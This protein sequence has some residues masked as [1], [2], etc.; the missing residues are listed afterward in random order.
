MKESRS[1]ESES[2]S[3]KKRNLLMRLSASSFW[4]LFNFIPQPFVT[5]LLR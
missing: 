2:R 4:L 5:I 3:Q 1:Q